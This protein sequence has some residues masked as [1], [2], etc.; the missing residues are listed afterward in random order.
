MYI[1]CALYSAHIMC[2]VQ[3]IYNMYCTVYIHCSL[4]SIHIM[5]ILECTTYTVRT[6]YLGRLYIER[7]C[8]YSLRLRYCVRYCNILQQRQTSSICDQDSSSATSFYIP[9]MRVRRITYAVCVYMPMWACIWR[10]GRVYGDV[11]VSSR[12][13]ERKG[14]RIYIAAA[15]P[16]FTSHVCEDI[17]STGSWSRSQSVDINNNNAAGGPYSDKRYSCYGFYL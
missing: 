15:P 13:D 9:E 2:L 3:Y 17:S 8:S 7:T 4:Y 1:Q 12:L 16:S 5:C 10:C 6:M 11:G 14:E